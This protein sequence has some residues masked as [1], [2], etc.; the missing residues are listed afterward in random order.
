[1]PATRN[2][3]I[4]GKVTFYP[5]RTALIGDVFLTLPVN[6]CHDLEIVLAEKAGRQR[7]NHTVY[8]VEQHSYG[9]DDDLVT[10]IAFSDT[11]VRFGRSIREEHW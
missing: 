6:L 2:S 7:D 8:K 9:T 11:S 5:Y 3:D 4:D 10:Y 1:M